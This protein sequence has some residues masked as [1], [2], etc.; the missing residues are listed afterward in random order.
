MSAESY[1]DKLTKESVKEMTL[2]EVNLA[3]DQLAFQETTERKREKI[4]EY[5]DVEESK[6]DN[7]IKTGTVVS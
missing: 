1:L 3:F 6:D 7:I 4:L 2:E 5:L